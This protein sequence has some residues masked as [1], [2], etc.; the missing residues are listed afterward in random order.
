MFLFKI[1]ADLVMKSRRKSHLNVKK[2]TENLFLAV[3]GIKNV[4]LYYNRD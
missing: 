2:L 3:L 1:W 4:K